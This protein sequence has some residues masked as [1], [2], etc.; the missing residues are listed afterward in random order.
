MPVDLYK[1]RRHSRF[2]IWTRPQGLGEGG[3]E[4]WRL[5]NRRRQVDRVQEG[6]LA[7]SRWELKQVLIDHGMENQQGS[8]AFDASSKRIDW[9]TILH[10]LFLFFIQ[11]ILFQD[12]LIV[13]LPYP[14]FQIN[15]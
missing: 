9:D 10:F 14:L 11:L 4:M 15:Q 3:F 6:N 1:D 2:S 5:I 7:A 13:P 8:M 12:P